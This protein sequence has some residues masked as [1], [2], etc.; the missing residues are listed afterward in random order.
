MST[1]HPRIAV[2]TIST[3]TWQFPQAVELLRDLGVG[4]VGILYGMI[5]DDPQAAVAAMNAAG[6]ACSNVTGDSLGVNLLDPVDADGSPALRG[7]KPS[8][9]FAASLGK[10]PCYFTT[11]PTP[12]RMPTDE[13]FDRAVANAAPILAYAKKIGV[14]L[15]LEHNNAAHRDVGFVNTL[16]HCVEFSQATGIGICLEIQNC[17]IERDLPRLFRENMDRI[18]VVQVSDYL[19]GETTRMN[20]R[21]LGDGSIPLEWLL[22]HLLDAGYKGMF[23][24]ETL[25]PAIEAEGYASAIRRSLDWLNQRLIS[26]GV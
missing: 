19:V 12:P 10:R 8:L 26:W 23:E 25:G 11:G 24:I 18:T 1:I 7:L 17:W 21:V 4:Y 15:A 5:R 2:S 16:H 13:A 14:P 3:I 20:R 9:D 6:I 22:G